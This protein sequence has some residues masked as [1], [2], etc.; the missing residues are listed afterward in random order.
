MIKENVFFS[1]AGE[2]G[3]TETSAAHLCAV[4]ANLKEDAETFLKN[5]SFTDA[6]L[7]IVGS[8]A[9]E[10]QINVG[11][12]QAELDTVV[13]KL[14]FIAE[15]NGFIAWFAEARK[16]L[17]DYKKERNQLS[18]LDWAEENGVKLP[19]PPKNETNLEVASSLQD[20]IDRMNVKDRQV[21]LAL[22][23]KAATL[24]KFIHPDGAMY[25]AREDMHN[26]MSKPYSTNGN[27]RDTLVYHYTPSVE[28]NQ[29]DTLFLALQAEYR[30]TEQNLNHM[31][32]DLR[33]QL[34]VVNLEENKLK[35]EKLNAFRK[36][37]SEYHDAYE[38][39][40][41]DYQKYMTEQLTELSKIKLR[42]PEAY[43]SLIEKL[44]NLGK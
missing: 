7:S 21:Y 31:K 39:A 35:G 18:L 33:K 17:E 28:A 16:A 4:A 24:G 43:A 22:E 14:T 2:K 30:A 11:C 9:S 5:M 26:K 10:K 25:K 23:A 40:Y 29:V 37:Q 34:E 19:E 20:I 32:S 38:I 15:L 36:A 27:G 6:N 8:E 12:S 41:N 44:N 1:A 3:L 42:I 13:E